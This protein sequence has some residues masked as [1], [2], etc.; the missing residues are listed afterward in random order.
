MARLAVNES[1]RVQAPVA[2]PSGAVEIITI[3]NL[4]E[5]P[6][7]TYVY[8]TDETVDTAIEKFRIKYGKPAKMIY[9]WKVPLL[10]HLYI[11]L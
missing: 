10:H 5:L 11:P 4:R 6:A 1:G 8:Y 9:C 3:E 2:T 7:G